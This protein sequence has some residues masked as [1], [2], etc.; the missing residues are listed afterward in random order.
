VSLLALLT[1]EALGHREQSLSLLTG[2]PSILLRSIVVQVN[3]Y[4]ELAELRHEPR[5]LT[6]IDSNHIRQ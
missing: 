3:R 4:P 5:Y 6:L 1:F 2:S